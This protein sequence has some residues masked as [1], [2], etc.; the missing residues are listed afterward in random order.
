MNKKDKNIKLPA[1]ESDLEE[2]S[3]SVLNTYHKVIKCQNSNQDVLYC[4]MFNELDEKNIENAYNAATIYSGLEE[5]MENHKMAASE[6]IVELI[7]NYNYSFDFYHNMAKCYGDLVKYKHNNY[8][9]SDTSLT[10]SI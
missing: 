10:K 9:N 1:N 7:G 2:K 4:S 5:L 8:I 3:L 6:R